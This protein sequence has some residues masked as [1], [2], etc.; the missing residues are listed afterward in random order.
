[1]KKCKKGDDMEEE[2]ISSHKQRLPIRI[3][4]WILC[5]VFIGT[6]S[7]AIVQGTK[8]VFQEKKDWTEYIDLS[9]LNYANYA[10]YYRAMQAKD[11]G[12]NTVES[13]FFDEEVYTQ[14][15]FESLPWNATIEH[16]NRQLDCSDDL[17]YV[18]FDNSSKE[19]YTN[20]GQQGPLLMEYV[21]V[22]KNPQAVKN[23]NWDRKMKQKFGY[24]SVIQYDEK[25]N[26]TILDCFGKNK[27]EILAATRPINQ[28]KTYEVPIYQKLDSRIIDLIEADP[29]SESFEMYGEEFIKNGVTIRENGDYFYNYSSYNSSDSFQELVYQAK[30]Y[31]KP[32]NI[33]NTT[34]I[35]AIEEPLRVEPYQETYFYLDYSFNVIPDGFVIVYLILLVIISIAAITVACIKSLGIA[36]SCLSKIP[37]EIVGIAATGVVL[38]AQPFAWLTRYHS[39]GLL[40]RNLENGNLSTG[41]AQLI[42]VMLIYGGWFLYFAVIFFGIISV[43]S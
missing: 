40:L 20:A 3:I 11:P 18:V 41:I 38:V 9:E 22:I 17:S 13:C 30:G 31:V 2:K 32:S 27:E 26:P 6:C 12:K 36:T 21:D 8:S 34:M 7:I 4:A 25:G 29:A 1:M 39:R 35:V 37:V 33:K 43:L 15:I 10:M 28:L 5:F 19:I 23:E 42:D 14:D 24:Y 16:Y